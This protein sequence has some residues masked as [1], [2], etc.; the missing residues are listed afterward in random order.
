MAFLLIFLQSLLLLLSLN[1]AFAADPT[2]K[3][4]VEAETQGETVITVQNPMQ[5]PDPAQMDELTKM[6]QQN[7][8]W[9]MMNQQDFNVEAYKKAGV[10]PGD[11]SAMQPGMTGLPIGQQQPKQQN[12]G[13]VPVPYDVDE[14]EIKELRERAR[15]VREVMEITRVIDPRV[16]EIIE[17]PGKIPEINLTQGYGTVI[18][19]P[20]L[21]EIEDIA[22]GDKTLFSIDVRENSVILFPLKPFKNTN[23]TIFSKSDG[24]HQ[25]LLVENT[26]ANTADFHVAVLPYKNSPDISGI[27][28][29]IAITGSMPDKESVKGK[30]IEKSN[31]KIEYG[32][33]L[34]VIRKVVSQQMKVFV[35]DG[36][37]T[38]VTYEEVAWYTVLDNK[39][40][41][42]AVHGET[43]KDTFVR[44]IYDG[45]TFNI[46]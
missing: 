29:D 13:N 15:R 17:I 38:P 34:P 27:V 32:E 30:L 10:Q 21:F 35:L 4:N 11:T 39:M 1:S 46:R 40:T 41:L 6:Y 42:L 9:F 45:R 24:V 31:V 16:R 19:L 44:R 5:L 26:N 20:Y 36:R 33:K 22:L 37:Y 2:E 25:Y 43:S 28:R 18:S 7:P 14:K 12:L 3:K 23:L 8:G